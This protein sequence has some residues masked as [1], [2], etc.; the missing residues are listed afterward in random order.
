[1][2]AN[3]QCPSV[4]LPLHKRSPTSA[5]LLSLAFGNVNLS[6]AFFGLP[7]SATG[8]GSLEP[9]QVP[10]ML[11]GLTSVSAFTHKKKPG[12]C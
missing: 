2:Y 1:M 7:A 9:N 6:R 12:I 5:E 4:T 11:K 10:S 8:G 3:G